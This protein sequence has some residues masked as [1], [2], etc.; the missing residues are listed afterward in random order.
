MTP[1]I[2]HILFTYFD[3]IFLFCSP[4]LKAS[5]V[6]LEWLKS[7]NFE[8]PIL[9]HQI[10]SNLIFPCLLAHPEIVMSVAYTIKKFK[11][12]HPRLR[13]TPHCSTLKFCELLPFFIFSYPANSMYLA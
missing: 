5:C 3:F 12:W 11:I 7:L 10:L 13:G 4:I 6:E 2:S 1:E 8:G 9:V